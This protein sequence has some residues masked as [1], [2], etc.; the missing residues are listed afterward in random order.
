MMYSKHLFV[1]RERRL[2]MEHNKYEKIIADFS[3]KITG[4]AMEL[5]QATEDQRRRVQMEIARLT[6][7][8]REYAKEAARSSSQ[9]P[10]KDDGA[11]VDFWDLGTPKQRIYKKPDFDGHSV[12]TTPIDRED[13]SSRECFSAEKIP[14]RSQV[15]SQ[16][17]ER[18]FTS[19]YRRNPAVNRFFGNNS[20]GNSP[21]T[22]KILHSYEPGG[23]LLH[24][25]TVRSWETEN[26]FYGRFISD[27]TSSHK[28]HSKFDPDLHIRPV[29]YQSYV[30]QYSHMNSSQVDYYRWLRE[31]IRLG[32]YPDCDPAYLQLYI[33][34]IFNLPELIPPAEGVELLASIWLNYRSRHGRLDGYLCEWFADYCLTN[35]CS[36]PKEL[37]PI[38]D[39]IAPKAQFKEFYI[40]PIITAAVRDGDADSII[41]LGKTVIEVSSD[42]DYKSARYYPDNKEAYDT[43]IPKAVGEA[44]K[45]LIEESAEPFALDRLYKMTRDSF[46]GAVVAGG[47]KKRVDIEFSSF[48]RRADVRDAITALVK[49]SENKV[50]ILLG[51]KSKL[52]LDGLPG[53]SESVIDRYFAPILPRETGVKKEDEFMPRDYLKLYESEDYGFEFGKAAEIERQSWVNTE[54]LTGEEY[55]DKAEEYQPEVEVSLDGEITFEFAY[56]EETQEQEPPKAENSDCGIRDALAAALDGGFRNYCRANSLYDGEV[57]DRI[58]TLF[59]DIIGDVVLEDCGNGYEIIEDYRED[60]ENWLQ[61]Q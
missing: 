61:M 10:K 40:D 28:A 35:C 6:E 59:L 51:I 60:A 23:V 58:N 16:P 31:N 39:V 8:I 9:T 42:Y 3:A 24:K 34:E 11:T 41:S 1:F 20:A 36:L 27:A 29:P 19:S 4:L 12:S 47:I 57:A 48:T 21:R 13:I 17:T 45:S 44:V 33:Y 38:L 2:N 52:R 46:N 32:R 49:Y 5:T 56:T 7:E 15:S 53:T 26:E 30:P 43:H 55:V 18:R 25:I 14:P 37:L 50:R 22:S 54:R